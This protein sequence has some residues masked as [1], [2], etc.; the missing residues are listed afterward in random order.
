M[1]CRCQR[2][3]GEQA[4]REN[5]HW[6]WASKAGHGGANGGWFFGNRLLASVTEQGVLSGWLLATAN[7]SERFVLQA[8]L[9]ARAGCPSLD[10]P[11]PDAHHTHTIC[12]RPSN[13]L[14]RFRRLALTPVGLIWPMAASI[15]NAGLTT[16]T[17]PP[18]LTSRLAAILVLLGR[19]PFAVC[20]RQVVE[21]VFA[22]L[23]Q[24]FDLKPVIAHSYLGLYTR[25]AA[26]AAAFNLGILFNRRYG[27]PDFAYATLIL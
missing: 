27:R 10:A 20:T 2:I 15:P 8:L 1:G 21:T 4:L 16:G 25:V 7:G 11:D 26:K 23:S 6:L 24:V 9:S 14:T 13:G 12:C 18:T 5:G 3:A 19:L 22:V 17:A